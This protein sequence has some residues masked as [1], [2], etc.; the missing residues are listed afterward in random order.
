[1]SM[2]CQARLLYY[3]FLETLAISWV[4]KKQLIETLQ[5]LFDKPVTNYEV[6]KL[7]VYAPTYQHIGRS[8]TTLPLYRSNL[9]AGRVYL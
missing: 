9:H 1:M 8:L 5:D 2:L 3:I 7:K 6:Y 4:T